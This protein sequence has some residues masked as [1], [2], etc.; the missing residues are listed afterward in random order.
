VQVKALR[1][2]GVS[3]LVVVPRLRSSAYISM[4]SHAFPTIRNAPPGNIQE[5][6]LSDLRNL[7][8]VNN[9]GSSRVFRSEIESVKSM[10]DFR[11][12][13]V[14]REDTKEK[15]LHLETQASLHESDVINLQFTRFV[16]CWLT[17]MSSDGHS[18][19]DYRVS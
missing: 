1:L 10:I 7:I 6:E 19:R 11:E 3:H 17:N 16:L 15:H 14:W 4:L 18:Q 5:E 9:T 2:A 12:L 8:V 13:M